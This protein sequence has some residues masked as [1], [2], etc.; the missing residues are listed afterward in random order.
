MRYHSGFDLE[1][2]VGA[3]LDE[4]NDSDPEALKIILLAA[5]CGLRRAEIDALGWE[6]FNFAR[7]IL[8]IEPNEHFQ[9]KSEDSIGSIDLEARVAEFFQRL[10]AKAMGS[11]VVQSELRPKAT[12]ATYASYRCQTIF[13]RVTRWLRK[14][15]V[16]GEKPLHQLRKEFGSR[17]CDRYGIYASSRMLR[18]GDVATTAA[19]YLDKKAKTTVGLEHLFASPTPGPTTEASQ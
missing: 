14:H 18:H 11:F 5:T 8:H 17:I 15:G 16:R 10:K 19:H 12:N 9:P 13:E 1:A 2:V 3:A 6:A 4:L 7:L